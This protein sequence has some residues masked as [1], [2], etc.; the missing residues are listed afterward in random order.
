[1]NQQYQDTPL[2]QLAESHI[3]DPRGFTHDRERL[4]HAMIGVGP[5]AAAQQAIEL[6][7]LVLKRRHH[8]INDYSFLL[9][10][11]DLLRSEEFLAL[12][13]QAKD[14]LEW[15]VTSWLEWYEIQHENT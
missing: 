7:N 2:N 4:L 12:D 9:A 10:V 14:C 15:C 11:E 3:V 5:P 8:E 1:M 6:F 13:Q